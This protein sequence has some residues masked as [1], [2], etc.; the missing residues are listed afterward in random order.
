MYCT[1]ANFLDPVVPVSSCQKHHFKQFLASMTSLCSGTFSVW[2]I[3]TQMALH[4][5]IK[6]QKMNT[7]TKGW[8]DEVTNIPLLK[9]M[10]VETVVRVKL[11]KEIGA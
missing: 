3:C 11:P 6:K 4:D 7:I 5:N 9:H 10:M 8:D 1:N 2:K